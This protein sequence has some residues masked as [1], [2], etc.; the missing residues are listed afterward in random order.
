VHSS[1]LS[2]KPVSVGSTVIGGK[3]LTI[4]SGPCAIETATQIEQCAQFSKEQ[5]CHI[6]RGGAFKPRSSPHDFQGLGINGLEL[7]M[8]AAR[9]VQLPV[10]TEL[11]DIRHLDTY[12]ELGIDMIQV[13]SRNM[14]NYELLKELGQIQ[15][16]VLL[17][18]GMAAT[19]KEWL[20][21]AEYIVQGGN[22]QIVL[23]ERGIRSFEPNYRNMLD[24][25]AIPSLKNTT[26]FPVIVDP[27]HACGQAHFVN[28]LAK[29]AIAAGADG[30]LIE[31]HPTPNQALSDAEQAL[32]FPAFKQ[33]YE[34]LQPLA[35]AVGRVL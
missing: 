12:L 33:L 34:E 29:A 9:Q 27:S 1:Q 20:L 16:P 19:I 28:S 32:T 21:A 30:L 10:V 13:G 5:H 8:A 3:Q 7:L 22:E 2:T 4:I 24:I 17:K 11:L 35:I 15:V 23:C 31:I 25:S 26:H 18:R 6:L 14:Q